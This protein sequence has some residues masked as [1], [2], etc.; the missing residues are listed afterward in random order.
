MYKLSQIHLLR[1][2]TELNSPHCSISPHFSVTTFATL[3]DQSSLT[4]NVANVI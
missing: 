1:R 4:D 3:Y 2:R